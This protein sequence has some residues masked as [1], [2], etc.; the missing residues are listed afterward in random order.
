MVKDESGSVCRRMVVLWDLRRRVHVR[1]LG[2]AIF[3]ESK[4]G[5]LG[6]DVVGRTRAR[7]KKAG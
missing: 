2:V 1:G 6:V 5:N 4:G 7:T 3:F